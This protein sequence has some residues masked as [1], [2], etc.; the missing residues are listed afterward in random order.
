MRATPDI[1]ARLTQTGHLPADR[2]PLA[3]TALTLASI[4]RPGAPLEPYRR[5]LKKLVDEVGAYAESGRRQADEDLRAEALAQ[6]IARRYGYLG[7]DEVFDEH[8]AANLMYAID[9][10][11][12][13]P[14]VLGVIYIHVGQ[15]L[16]WDIGGVNFPGRFLVGLSQGDR[17]TIIDPFD[18][19][20]M[21]VARDMRDILKALSG[22]QAE[23]TQSQ[24]RPMDNRGVLLRLQ[25]NIKARLL[26]AERL[27]EA[28]D[29]LETMLLFAPE[30]GGLWRELGLLHARL[31][32]VKTAIAA[33][34][35]HMRFNAGDKARYRTSALLQEL[36]ARLS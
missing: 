33:L 28:A 30:E 24:Y 19:G 5:H 8:E 36:R 29:I 27:E 15:E 1:R 25:D 4:D 3:E 20:D 31:D 22:N 26:R 13:L 16:G 21:L 12:G 11:S 14:V 7:K 23:L 32:N 18:A 17:R 35:E 10:R 2:I 9:R 34:E 6:V